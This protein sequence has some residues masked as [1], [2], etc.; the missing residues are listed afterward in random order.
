MA[1]MASKWQIL[2]E[3][4][5]QTYIDQSLEEKNAYVAYLSSASGAAA[6][7]QA[8]DLKTKR[9]MRKARKKIV[10]DESLKRPDTAFRIWLGENKKNLIKQLQIRKGSDLIT[11][12]A[13]MWKTLPESDKKT[14]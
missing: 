14:F 4:E 1:E 6:L 2:P 8:K 7:K 13:E 5:K 3:A 9:L 10:K 11:K 12:S